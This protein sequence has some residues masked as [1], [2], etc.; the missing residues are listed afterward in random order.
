M[1]VVWT[2]PR[3]PRLRFGLHVEGNPKRIKG[4]GPRPAPVYDRPGRNH[5]RSH[6][7]RRQTATPP[8]RRETSKC[9]ANAAT[10]RSSVAVSPFHDR[11]A[12]MLA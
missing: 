4:V 7:A 2:L 5:G 11:R 9:F 3:P 8:V 1:N 10:V 6:R 12:S